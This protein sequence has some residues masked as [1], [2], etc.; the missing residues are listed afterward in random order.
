MRWWSIGVAKLDE[1]TE[2]YVF[3]TSEPLT[4]SA[5]VDGWETCL[6]IT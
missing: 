3:Y 6:C 1:N 5:S 4:P 2:Y